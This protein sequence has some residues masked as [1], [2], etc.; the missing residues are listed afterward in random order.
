GNEDNITPGMQAIADLVKKNRAVIVENVDHG[1]KLF[2]REEIVMAPFWN[3][4]TSRSRTRG[5]RSSSSSSPSRS[6][7]ATAS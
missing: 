4:R 6:P 2:E 5:C 7:S 1:N 3:G